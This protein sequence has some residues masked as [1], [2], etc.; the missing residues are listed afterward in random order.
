VE[1]RDARK[2][3]N[4]ARFRLVNEGITKTDAILTPHAAQLEV[5]CECTR[6]ECTTVITLSRGDYERVREVSTQFIV[7]HGHVDPEVE[8][9]VEEG[10][11]HLVVRKREGDAADVARATDPRR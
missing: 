4:E 9:V 3:E 11:D 1:T 2:G 5:F 6:L 8:M 7:G 10:A